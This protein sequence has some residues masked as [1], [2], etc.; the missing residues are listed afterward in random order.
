[1]ADILRGIYGVSGAVAD[2]AL[3]MDRFFVIAGKHLGSVGQEIVDGD[4]ETEDR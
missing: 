4:D 2:K 1:M 3:G